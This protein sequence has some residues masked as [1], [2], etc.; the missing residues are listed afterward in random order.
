MKDQKDTIKQVI[1][2]I[3]DN[4][5][6]H[7]GLDTIAQKTGYSKFYL[8]RV[9]T[10][11]TGI[12]IHKY[13]QNRR[14]TTAAEKLVHSRKPITTIA[15]EGGFAIYDTMQYIKCPVSTICI[16]LAA[17]FG[18]FLLAGGAHGR[19][20]ALA[21]SQI[22]IHQPAIHGNGIQGQATDIKILSC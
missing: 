17:S 5:E 12:T 8:N 13:L 20:M 10:W 9:F 14:L 2:Y 7:I 3:E 11:Q 16:G 15:Y 4:L 21:N 18:A 22:M 6:N 1:D 19:R